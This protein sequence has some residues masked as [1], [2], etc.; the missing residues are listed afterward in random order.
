MKSARLTLII[1]LV[2]LLV[3]IGWTVRTGIRLP[4]LARAGQ[5]RQAEIQE[6]AQMQA[7]YDTWQ[8]M[9]ATLEPL[10]EVL[11][12]DIRSTLRND[13]PGLRV[14]VR[15]QQSEPIWPGW[16]VENYRVQI[17]SVQRDILG[18][19]LTTLEKNRPPWRLTAIQIDAV[20]QEFDQVRLTLD[21]ESVRTTQ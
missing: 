14:D 21:L 20:E 7:T 2:L 17:S 11:G 6:L 5:Q 19:V 1:S 9:I 4:A 12:A 18:S 16:T 10:E 8:A 15:L 13:F 3:A